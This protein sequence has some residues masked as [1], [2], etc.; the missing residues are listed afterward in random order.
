MF[1]LEWLG[2]SP[3]WALGVCLAWERLPS[4]SV[5]SCWSAFAL[6]M[7]YGLLLCH[8]L[9][10]YVSKS[11]KYNRYAHDL[12]YKV[13]LRNIVDTYPFDEFLKLQTTK[14]VGAQYYD[15]VT[16]GFLYL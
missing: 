5:C 10:D 2:N 6:P 7:C 4:C 8:V 11:I 9:L 16:N 1:K 12:L 13:C 14:K 3:M 15:K